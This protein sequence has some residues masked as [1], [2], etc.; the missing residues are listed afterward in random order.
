MNPDERPAPDAKV[1]KLCD[2]LLSPC[3]ISLNA[4]VISIN[5]RIVDSGGFR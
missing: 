3:P 1:S 4:A 5:S 2:Q